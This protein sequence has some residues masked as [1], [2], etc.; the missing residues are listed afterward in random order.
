MLLVLLLATLSWLVL[1]LYSS[2][3]IDA[4]RLSS[5][6]AT[7]LPSFFLDTYCLSM[8]SVLLLAS[9]IS[10]PWLV[11]MFFSSLHID[12]SV[13]SS[14]LATAVTPFFLKILGYKALCIIINILVLWSICLPLSI[15]GMVQGI[16]ER[17]S[18]R[19]LSIWRVF[20]R[21]F[22]FW[23]V[24]SFIG[25]TLLLFFFHLRSFDGVHFQYSQVFVFFLF[26]KRSDSF[27]IWHFYSFRYFPFSIFHYVHG[28]FFYAG[29]H[30]YILS[31][32]SYCLY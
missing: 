24:L 6:L 23:E 5:L 28:T 17:G 26:S 25:S 20:C 16:L 1:M 29:F 10:L 11:L 13:L 4:S 15:F 31:V 19:S 21:R 32:Y 22:W 18:P 3:R 14:L 7:P 12:A 27:L 30:S 8:L 9:G 2:H